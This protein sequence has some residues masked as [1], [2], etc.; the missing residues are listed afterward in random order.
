MNMH[1]CSEL[2]IIFSA[3][4]A[5][6]VPEDVREQVLMTN[7]LPCVKVWCYWKCFVFVFPQVYLIKFDNSSW[8]FLSEIENLEWKKKK[9]T[10]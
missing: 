3:D 5:E 2:H 10:V 6:K 1:V 7:L 8:E 9:I 4:F